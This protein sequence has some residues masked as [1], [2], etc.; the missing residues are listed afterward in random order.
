MNVDKILI[1]DQVK[2]VILVLVSMHALSLNV[3]PMQ[4]A[5][6]L[7][8][9]LCVLASQDSLETENMSVSLVSLNF[10]LCILFSL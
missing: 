2:F 9:T 10:K 7:F 5:K 4:L 6:Q 1:A 3:H 8:M